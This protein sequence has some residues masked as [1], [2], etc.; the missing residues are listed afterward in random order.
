MTRPTRRRQSTPSPKSTSATAPSPVEPAP[1][2]KRRLV[3][4]LV[5]G[6][7]AVGIAA[8]IR[9]RVSANPVLR[10]PPVETQDLLPLVAKEIEEK[11]AA[12]VAAPDSPDT[13][14][15]YG[16]V[17]LAHGF[18]LEAG[19]CFAEAE[20]LD[21]HDYRW[22]YYYG[23]T[24]GIW[25]TEK[26]L[27]AFERA[28]EDAPERVTVRLRLAEWLFD[29]RH[30]DD[31]QHQTE[32]VLQQDPNNP[33]AELLMARLRF[34]DG[35]AEESLK[36]AERAAASAKGNRR[37][38][39][40]LLARIYQRL[41]HSELAAEEVDRTEM[42][43][44]GVT[45]WDDPEMGVGATY[46][47]DA[48][49]LNTLANIRHARGDTKGWIQLLQ[50][51]VVT[52]PDNVIGKE[53]LAQALVDTKQYK[54][55]ATYI[56]KTLAD[57]PES[58][59]LECLRGQIDLAQEKPDAAREHFE[60]AVKLKPDYAAAFIWLGRAQLVVG[61]ADAAVK[62]LQTATR[63]SP[64]DAE[65]YD[66]LGRAQ[67]ACGKPQDAIGTWQEAHQLQP[68]CESVAVQLAQTLIDE[69][70]PAE[71]ATVLRQCIAAGKNTQRAAELLQNLGD[72]ASPESVPISRPPPDSGKRSQDKPPP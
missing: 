7:L 31:C 37:D 43:P 5:L 67:V 6:L 60:H 20:R 42:L 40:E 49:I 72:S 68:G 44:R 4:L 22:P 9:Y 34:Q 25:D 59:Q 48:S 70:R 33:R 30:L 54:E 13:W 56:D 27:R 64:S 36:W 24:M 65:A 15:E 51:V 62:N 55:A 35:Q 1:P 21:P 71:A 66:Y 16:L 39:H 52:E 23:M 50:Q 57:H 12:I 26:S 18:R 28:V 53:K 14:G 17:L 3:V 58:A 47:K 63:L 45:V 10:I 32:L 38:V 46:L 11:Q 69:H 19:D 2:S 8:V 29:L 41:G 61:K